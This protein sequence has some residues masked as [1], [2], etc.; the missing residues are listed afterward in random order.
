MSLSDEDATFED[1]FAHSISTNSLEENTSFVFY[2][3]Y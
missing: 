2:P 1:V 3:E